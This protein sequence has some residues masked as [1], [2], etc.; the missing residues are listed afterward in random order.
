M[1][2]AITRPE[3]AGTKP[4][5]KDPK[6]TDL[7]NER[8]HD[9]TV[10]TDGKNLEAAR[11]AG[12][13]P[14]SPDEIITSNATLANSVPE[15]LD[16]M[17]GFDSRPGGNHLLLALEPGYAVIDKGMTAPQGAYSADHQYDDPRPVG[18]RQERGRIHYA[19]NHLRPTRVIELHRLK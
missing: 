13:S 12:H 7:H 15:A 16:G 4:A 3:N 14:I 8:T 2:S 9:S 5:M 19:L 1:N 18:Q 17:A 11:I 10:D 6:S